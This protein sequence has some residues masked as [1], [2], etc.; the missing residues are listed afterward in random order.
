M[1][2]KVYTDEE[3]FAKLEERT[4]DKVADLKKEFETF[5]AE[6]INDPKL[7]KYN[8]TEKRS[9]IRNRFGTNKM[10]LMGSKTIPWEGVIVGVGDNIDT[11]AKQKRLTLALYK[12]DRSKA[13]QPQG[14]F[15]EK[16]LV[17]ASPE[18]IP[19]YPPTELNKK[20]GRA[21]KPL[22]E[23]SW[24]RTLYLIARPI[25]PKTREAGPV[26]FSR[27]RINGAPAVD[28]SAIPLMKPVKFRAIN[29]TNDEDRLKGEYGLNF[30]KAYTKFTVADIPGMP[31][32]EDLLAGIAN[33]Y[34]SLG[35]LE[36]Y[37]DENAEDPRRVV[38]T[39]G[40]VV[41]MNLEPNAK[42]GNVYIL[43]TDE[44]LLFSSTDKTSVMCWIP[45]DRNI[46]TDYGVDSR[47]FLVAKTTRGKARDP[48]TGET[49]EGVPGDV[50]L[51]VYGIFAPEIFKVSA[52]AVA[53]TPSAIVAEEA[54]DEEED[55]DEEEP[56]G[57]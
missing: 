39:E 55:I 9:I 33:H 22:P 35:G 46:D 43:V 48:L 56:S 15:Y 52:G 51:N 6:S 38:I 47:V 25:N 5:L 14:A 44:S 24:L 10:R 1:T 20:F 29:K 3:F 31:P 2:Q 45:T 32:I 30:S 40:T 17:K 7:V 18:G 36:I 54:S 8:E 16:R 53:V 21:N 26:Q 41:N 37:H 27:L 28:M 42:T 12:Q 11:V 50:M 4:G 57:W 19:L 49:L 13:T 34:E 23:H